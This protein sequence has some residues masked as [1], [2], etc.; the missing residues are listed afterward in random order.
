MAQSQLML[1]QLNS[2]LPQS[3]LINP[4]LFPDYKVTVGLPVLS[5]TYVSANGGQ[6]S[7]DNAFTRSADDSLHFNPQKLADNLD[8]NNRLE[9]NSN[10]QL[11]YLG[12]KANENYFSLS[13]NERIEA[14]LTY[15]KTFVQLLAGGN[16]AYEGQL[17]AFDGLGLRAQAYHELAASYGRDIN[18]K[19]S[20][21]IR[22]KFLSG[23]AGIDVDNISAGL[24]TSTDSLYLYSSAFNINMAGYD[25][26][27]GTDDI[28]Q[29]ATAFKNKG[30]AVDIGAHYWVNDKLR[31][32]MAVNDLGSITWDNNT[33]QIQFDEVNYSFT[34]IDFLEVLNQNNDPDLLTQEIDSLQELFE[35]DTVNG[36][37]Y[38]TKLAPKFYVGGSYHVG[39][40][41]TFGATFY[42]DVF[43]GTFKPAFGLS[44][45]LQL[46]HIWTIG[47]NASY[48]NSSFNNIGIGTTL[49]LGPVQLYALTENVT[50][51]TGPADARVLDA[52]VGMNLVFGKLK[53]PKKKARQQKDLEP[54]PAAVLL[55]ADSLSEPI[56]IATKGTAEDEL[57]T[58]Y[59]V[60]IAGIDTKEEAEMYN[61][62]L[63]DEGYAALSGYQSEHNKYYTYLMYSPDDGNKVIQKKNELKESFSPGLKKP[64]VLWVLWVKEKE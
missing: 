58:G 47:I 44:Y 9:I 10:V 61:L 11:F 46:G 59:Y 22:A 52:R 45:N 15:P 55:A 26:I 57:A 23:V 42:C 62:R 63:L 54:D 14:G 1:Y 38:K 48:R 30:F 19:L 43:K 25:L 39:K 33:R 51:L 64:W 2:R 27:D 56:V 36:I 12:L 18:D 3:N 7:F 4:G 13:L 32:S 37:S 50:A 35:P 31:V 5:S 41:H 6:L 53:K 49:T 28:F 20:I 29:S 21:G 40:H 8:E 24:L 17:L 60:I 16:G 34:G